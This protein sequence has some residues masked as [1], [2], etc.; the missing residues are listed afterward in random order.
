MPLWVAYALIMV[1]VAAILLETIIPS[2]GLIGIIGGGGS[3]LAAIAL[4]YAHRGP[5]DGTIVLISS[6]FIVPFAVSIGFKIFPRTPIGRRLIHA[7]SQTAETGYTSFTGSDYVDLLGA[8]GLS[9]T[10][11][12]PVGVARINGKKYSVVSA[13]EYIER[14]VPVRVIRVEGSRIVVRRPPEPVITATHTQE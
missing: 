4:T 10:D 9:I 5:L 3:I 7:T 8:E 14:N 2:F 11:L 13:G 1:G 6:M 12:R